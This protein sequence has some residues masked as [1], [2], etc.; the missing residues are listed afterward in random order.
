MDPIR[1]ESLENSADSPANRTS[2]GMDSLHDILAKKKLKPPDEM[3]AI[4]DYIQRKYKSKSQVKLER[5]ALIVRVPGSG[6]AAT[7]QLERQNIIK[8]CKLDKKLVIRSGF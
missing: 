6:L 5:G 3:A 7:L 4:K 2:N 8:A 1:S